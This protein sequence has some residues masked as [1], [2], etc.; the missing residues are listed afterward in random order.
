MNHTNTHPSITADKPLSGK[1]LKLN[2]LLTILLCASTVYVLILLAQPVK[3]AKNAYARPYF[4]L[5]DGSMY[6]RM[7]DKDMDIYGMTDAV[8]R[9]DFGKF[10]TVAEENMLQLIIYK[11]N[12]YSTRDTNLY[13]CNVYKYKD[14]EE[15][16][17]FDTIDEIVL[18]RKIQCSEDGLLQP[19][20]FL[21]VHNITKENIKSLRVVSSGSYDVRQLQNTE[22]LSVFLEHFEQPDLAETGNNSEHNNPDSTTTSSDM[23]SPY[24]VY[25]IIIRTHD[26]CYVL[27]DYE[28]A[29]SLL[30][31]AD[32]EYRLSDEF[33]VWLYETIQSTEVTGQIDNSLYASGGVYKDKIN[34]KSIT[35]LQPVHILSGVVFILC[36]ICLT[37]FTLCTQDNLR[38]YNALLYRFIIISKT[39]DSNKKTFKFVFNVL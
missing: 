31:H 5:E 32:L 2:L 19:A 21:N 20:E 28:P 16:I 17:L 27:L 25:D 15:F 14:S 23:I 37:P 11:D 26:N 3:T 12:E 29:N 4:I 22:T 38:Q 8:S 33:N 35:A 10:F 30:R 34:F 9:E 36:L 13:N 39:D 24:D 1:L 18:F 6:I 7:T